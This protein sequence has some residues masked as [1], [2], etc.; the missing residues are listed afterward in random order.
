MFVFSKIFRLAATP[1]NLLLVAFGL[2]AV[3]LWTRWR[4]AG[5]W[6]V[7][8]A[9]L[10]LW[11]VALFPVGP[12]LLAPLESRFPAPARLPDRLDGIVVLGGAVSQRLTAHWGQPSLNR[13]A[14]RMTAFVAL[15]RRYPEAR[16]FYTGGSGL[17]NRSLPAETVVARSFFAE[18]GLD[19]A[20]I[21]FEGESRNTHENALF[22]L[23][24]ARPAPGEA[25][26][27][28]TSAFHMPRA[29]ASFRAAGWPVI[30]YPVD[31][32][33]I[34]R[35]FWDVSLGVTSG[36]AMFNQA[37]HEWIGLSAYRLLGRTEEMFPA[38][39]P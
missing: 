13:H 11:A 12:A 31:Y 23:R 36:L 26:L 1:A 25:W 37:V 15:A 21:G 2:G 39:A 7:A 9:A 8:A 20:R 29:V 6:L 10:A 34:Y 19:L 24:M 16:L 28:I 33:T 38:P 17:L 32:S 18:Q 30:P 4:R 5:R 22:T 3:L 27:L 35:G 14:E